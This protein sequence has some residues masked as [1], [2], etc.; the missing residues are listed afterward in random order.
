[1]L[2]SGLGG[3]NKGVIGL[4]IYFFTSIT[5]AYAYCSLPSG[6]TGVAPKNKTE[7]YK[8]CNDYLKTWIP[9]CV[10][11]LVVPDKDEALKWCQEH[12]VDQVKECKS[13]YCNTCKPGKSS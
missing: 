12:G 7:C 6:M 2:K 1:M 10:E 3:Y 13:K 11:G 9:T 5:V 8:K 4:F